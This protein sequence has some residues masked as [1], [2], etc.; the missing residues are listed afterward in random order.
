MPATVRR[1]PFVAPRVGSPLRSSVHLAAAVSAVLLL[2]SAEALQAATFTVDRVDDAP[3]ATACDPAT[4]NDCSL[5]GAVLAAN[6][7]AEASTITVPAGTYVLSQPSTCAFRLKGADAPIVGTQKTLCVTRN[8]TIAGAGAAATMI[9][10][11]HQVGPVIAVS[12]DV[13][14]AHLEGMT[15]ANGNLTNPGIFNGAGGGINNNG[16]LTLADGRVIGNETAAFG[17]GGIYNLGSLTIARST[18]AQNKAPTSV[19]GGIYSGGQATLAVSDSTI[20]DNSAISGGGLFNAAVTN[21]VVTTSTISGNQAT[22]LGGGIFNSGSGGAPPTTLTITS[23]TISGN[24]SGSSGGGIYNNVV[25]SVLLNNVTVTDNTGAATN[26]GGRGG[27]LSNAF[28]G[29]FALQNTIVAGNHDVQGVA[30]DCAATAGQQGTSAFLSRGHNLIQDPTNCALSGDL[31]GNLLGV[32][33]LLGPLADNGGATATHV[34]PAESPAIDAGNPPPPGSGPLAC[35]A[36]DQRGFVR[37]AGAACDVGAF[38]RA[39]P[40]SLHVAP[41]HGGNGGTVTAVVYGFAGDG[42]A[43]VKLAR[44]GEPD[45]VGAETHRGASGILSA[46]F[47]LTGRAPGAWDVVVSA[48]GTSTTLPGGFT[49]EPGGAPDLW[50]DIIGRSVI[51]IGRPARFTVFYGNRG[52]VDAV[53]VPVILS[54]PAGFPFRVFFP[55]APPP[56]HPDRVREDWQAVPVTVETA[57][58]ATLASVP[59]LL[60]IVPSGYTGVLQFELTSPVDNGST[61]IFVGT[62]QPLFAPELDETNVSDAVAAAVA[63]LDEAGG[64]V[65]PPAVLPDVADYARTQLRAAVD[66]G[67]TAFVASLGTGLP[68]YSSARLHLDV[69]LFAATRVAETAT[70]ARAFERAV[71]LL[72]ALLGRL[73]PSAARAAGQGPPIAPCTGGVLREGETCTPPDKIF[74]PDIPPPPGCDLKDPTTFKHCKPTEAHCKNL[75]THLVVTLQNGDA[76]CVPKKPPKNCAKIDN[77]VLGSGNVSC[78][79]W[80]LAPRGSIDP[81]D[82]TGTLGAA[83]TNVVPGAMPLTYTVQFENL[84]T[85]TA[86]AQEVVVTDRLDVAALD[87]ATFS[88][89]PM[90]FGDVAISPAPGAQSYSGG[91]DLR[92]AQ[93]LVVLVRAALDA[94]TGI[95]TWRFTSAD[96]DTLELPDDPLAGFL[97][98]NTSPPAG[99]GSVVFS[100]AP[101]AGLSTGASVCNQAEIVFD[102]NSSIATPEWCNAFDGDAPASAVAALPALQ[103]STS[104]PLAWSGTDVGTGIL[105][106]SVFVSTNDGPFTPLV[107]DTTATSIQ[108]DGAPGNTYAFYSVARDLVGNV[109]GVTGADTVTH[110]VGPDGPHDLAV[111]KIAAPKT[112]A[113]SA[114]TPSKAVLV[115]VQVQNRGPHAETIADETVLQNLVT[116]DVASRGACPA[117]S[118]T[119]VKGAPQKKLPITIKSKKQSVAVFTVTLGCANDPAKTGKSEDHGDYTMSARVHHAALG[120]GDAHPDDDHCPRQVPP[121][122]VPDAFPNGKI[123]DRGCGTKKPDKTFGGDVVVDVTVKP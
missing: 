11:N 33:P 118:A 45:V 9:D 56:A 35:A 49:I 63:Y 5:R 99:D 42:D 13:D 26:A 114:K 89:G 115:K 6:G 64:V 69:A 16:T 52:N 120:G 105:D 79:V 60:P 85:A 101:R 22:S 43:T 90:G 58:N 7:L 98:P 82:K 19:G 96:P 87:L 1:C 59:L 76:L 65:V 80:P 23:S 94:A 30:P 18:I 24:Q 116:L 51:R 93:N 110:V 72:A 97:P 20:A 29:A 55:I 32:D 47:D 121:P 78:K 88:L 123:V 28:N 48:G 40:G 15:I 34:V 108:F 14:D 81:N 41:N 57:P 4:P 8:V 95:V 92:P 2:G 122:G 73:E 77:P 70:S 37:P 39:Q 17:G 50:V 71:G 119:L 10:G 46:R 44:S 117:P 103:T 38:E 53:G 100:I 83:P 21:A 107:R 12:G 25:T 66:E 3:S 113:L 91:V 106:Y 31:T 36:V 75:G 54:V 111:T 67:R 62:G 104:F 102:A 61:E 27:G 84:S 74:P 68:V 109:E 86:P 112:V